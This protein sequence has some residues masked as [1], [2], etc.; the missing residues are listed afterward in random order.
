MFLTLLLT[1]FGITQRDY[2]VEDYV[3]DWI[4]DE[5][6]KTQVS[7]LL[8][9]EEY[10][11]SEE[12]YLG[13]TC[14]DGTLEIY[15][16]WDIYLS[17]KELITIQFDYDEPITEEWVTNNNRDSFYKGNTT[18]FLEKLGTS[19]LLTAMLNDSPPGSEAYF[20]LNDTDQVIPLLRK[21]CPSEDTPP[22]NP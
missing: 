3:G 7:L 4:M 21:N 10:N 13:I 19:E 9:A 2:V 20:Q 22:N 11:N 8:Q 1:A 15:I 17:R 12:I 5:N 14:N 6:N 16:D 18:W